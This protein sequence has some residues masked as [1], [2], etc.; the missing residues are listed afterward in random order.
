MQLGIVDVV[1]IVAYFASMI[2]VGIWFSHKAAKGGIDSYFLADKSLPWYVLSVSHAAGMYDITGT[3]WLIYLCFV[4]GLKSVWIPWIYPMFIHIFYMVYLSVWVRRSNVR[5]GAEWIKTRFG[6]DRG[7]ELSYLSIVIWALVSVIGFLAYAF[8][9]I[10]KFSAALFPWDISPNSYAMIFMGIA[11]IY[12]MLGGLYSVVMNAL[13]QYSIL[14]IMSFVVGIIAISKVSP[15]M[16]DAVIPAGWKDV[17]FGWHLG[18]DWSGTIVSVNKC[19]ESDGWSLFAIFVAMMLF[20][21]FL[22]SS[23]MPAPNFDMQRILATKNPKQSAL[24][25]GLVS[26]VV[27]IPRYFLITGVTVL[28]LVYYSPQLKAMGPNIDFETIMPLVMKNFIPSGLMGFLL[29]GLIAAFMSNFDSTLNAGVAYVVNDVFKRFLAPNAKSRTYII[30]SYISSI[31][32][33]A[34][35]IAFGFFVESIGSVTKWL[36]V[37]LWGG[38]TAANLLKWYWWRLNGYGYFWGMMAGTISAILAPLLFRSVSDVYTFPIILAIAAI[39]SVAASLMTRPVDE[40][41]AKKFYTQTRPWGFWKPV[42]EK[43]IKENPGFKRNTNF[44]RD[45]FNIVIGIIW[46]TTITALPIYLV[47][48]Q[49]IPLSIGILILVVTSVILKKNWLDKL[50]EN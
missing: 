35:G 24:M 13:I 50:E 38:Y 7:A 48:K 31:V 21:G 36:F 25:S 1:I 46:Q 9:G 8:K 2:G 49:F 29:A 33:L 32:I 30:V 15:A 37:A 47:I 26:I 39:V 42:Y 5:T 14:T 28:A 18:L 10:G 20:K 4:Y 17:F 43:V 3:M 41:V 12:A 34:I 16:L 6:N 11:V 40:E 22:V 23:G 27:L 44:K 45:M 19:I